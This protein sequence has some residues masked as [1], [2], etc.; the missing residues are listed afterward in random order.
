MSA[1]PPDLNLAALHASKLKRLSQAM[2]L[3]EPLDSWLTR[4]VELMCSG[5]SAEKLRD[6]VMEYARSWVSDLKDK[7]MILVPQARI[8]GSTAIC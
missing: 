8:H 1:P 4:G 5:E 6:T 3:S 2:R 7:P